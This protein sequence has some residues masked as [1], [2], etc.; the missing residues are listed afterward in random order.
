MGARLE[1]VGYSIHSTQAEP[2]EW[3][4]LSPELKTAPQLL[5]TAES[6]TSGLRCTSTRP[7]TCLHVV[8]RPRNPQGIAPHH[9]KEALTRQGGF[10]SSADGPSGFAEVLLSDGPGAWPGRWLLDC[11]CWRLHDSATCALCKA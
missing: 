8:G 6:R 1:R 11:F 5:R 3:L 4:L 2:D 10:T 9:Q 7:V